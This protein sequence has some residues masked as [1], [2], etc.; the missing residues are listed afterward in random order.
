[1]TPKRLWKIDFIKGVAVILMVLWHTSYDLVYLFK[2]T[3]IFHPWYWRG[4][5]EL[6]SGLFL[7]SSG[8]GTVARF[9]SLSDSKKPT[10]P[11]E[12][13]FKGG[14]RITLWGCFLT[15]LTFKFTPNFIILFGILHLIGLCTLIGPLFVRVSPPTLIA[16]SLL[17]LLGGYLWEESQSYRDFKFWLEVVYLKRTMLDFYLPL[18]SLGYFTLGIAYGNMFF[19]KLNAVPKELHFNIRSINF[20]GKH[21]LYIYLLHQP[22]LIGVLILLGLKVNFS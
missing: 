8:L 9:K 6:I 14:L 12:I 21:S 19:S 2:Q 17:L 3:N 1:M 18:P 7:F 4:G 5:P 15:A 20:L 16:F 11:W 10:I 22:V 13:G